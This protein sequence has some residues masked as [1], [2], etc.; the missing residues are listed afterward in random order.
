VNT[1]RPDLFGE[2]ATS[3]AGNDLV[4]YSNIKNILRAYVVKIL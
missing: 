4:I 2:E 1:G 3:K